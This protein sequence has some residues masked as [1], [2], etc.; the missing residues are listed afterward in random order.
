[1]SAI[2]ECSYTSPEPSALTSEYDSIP[3]FDSFFLFRV[4]LN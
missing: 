4:T 2:W 3:G 1:M